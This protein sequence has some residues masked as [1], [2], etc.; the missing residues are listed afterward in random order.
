MK[1]VQLYG[2]HLLRDQMVAA[3]EHEGVAVQSFTDLPALYRRAKRDVPVIVWTTDNRHAV[4]AAGQ[5]RLRGFL[6]HRYWIG[7]DALRLMT[8][9]PF[10]AT[11]LRLGNRSFLSHTANAR[12]LAAELATAGIYASSLPINPACCAEHWPM[13][14]A[15]A[16]PYTVLYYSLAGN[17]VIYQP[18]AMIAA[19][20]A[21]PEVRFLAIGNH[22]WRGG[23]ANIEQRGVIS[24]E[25]CRDLYGECDAMVRYTSHDGLSRMVLEAMSS[26]LDVLF[27]HEIP[28]AH[29]VT[30][31]DDVIAR[32]RLLS[33][34][35]RGRN[36]AARNYALEHFSAGKW[37]DAW[38]RTFRGS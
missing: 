26:G 2:R 11:T 27:A 10:V 29:R 5:L 13:P 12:W 1:E 28:H 25:E 8:R 31:V 35:P 6:P 36:V 3:F 34:G 17:D 23:P 19:A 18:A 38:R 32:L 7:S 37:T 21:L 9:G 15:P 16:G 20:T 14:A 22:E 24:P 30:S 4:M 33:E